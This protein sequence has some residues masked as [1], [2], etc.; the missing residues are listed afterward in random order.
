MD[1]QVFFAFVNPKVLPLTVF[2]NFIVISVTRLIILKQGILSLNMAK[3]LIY[4]L[5]TDKE[6]D[7]K[8]IQ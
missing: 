6:V 3:T 2:K 4:Y 8:R 1:C 7:E 5:M